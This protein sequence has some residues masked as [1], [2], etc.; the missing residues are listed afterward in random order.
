MS[1]AVPADYARFV[2]AAR[3]AGVLPAAP[4]RL[5]AGVV[6]DELFVAAKPASD[7][8]QIAAKRA[9][10]LF[11]PTKRTE[12]VWVEGDSE[13]AVGFAVRL[14][15]DDGLLT[16]VIPVR[17]D[18]TGE[19]E[20]EVV[21][22]VGSPDRPAGLFASTFRKPSGPRL[23]V[24]TWSDALVAFAWQ[25]VLGM[26][27]GLAGAIGKDARGNVLVPVELA[28]SGRGVHVVPMA[29]HRF[30]GSSGLLTK[31]ARR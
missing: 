16:V 18:Q 25:S 15:V 29:R 12:V 17:C 23:V 30:A 27:S 21:F 14:E 7:M 26:V 13:L 5:A 22:A 20:V 24:D 10:G 3:L 1:S 9:A 4:D 8:L 31:P 28:V 19:G 2:R 11:R 6:T